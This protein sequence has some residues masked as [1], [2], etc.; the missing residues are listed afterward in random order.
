MNEANR[1]RVQQAL[2]YPQQFG[3]GTGS[4]ASSCD[5]R[6]QKAIL[7]GVRVIPRV[8]FVFAL[9]P[10]PHPYMYTSI[11]SS[12][13]CTLLVQHNATAGGMTPYLPAPH[14][15]TRNSIKIKPCHSV[16][17]ACQYTSL[18][19]TSGTRNYD[20]NTTPIYEHLRHAEL[21]QQ[22]YPHLRA[23]SAR[24]TTTTTLPPS[25]STF[26]TRSHSN[27]TTQ[28]YRRARDQRRGNAR[29]REPGLHIEHGIYHLEPARPNN[30]LQLYVQ[31]GIQRERLSKSLVDV[32][33]QDRPQHCRWHSQPP[34]CT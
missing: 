8:F 25:T 20:N 9:P 30:L 16:H 4:S 5:R 10:L 32:L 23:P 14:E 28:F 29:I 26:G 33:R 21:R 12:A 31:G 34:T 22:H 7:R 2:C 15:N 24:G 11:M 17:C 18:T 13:L 6:R 27:N 1:V 19:S 3:L